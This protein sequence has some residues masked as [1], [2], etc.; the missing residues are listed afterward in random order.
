MHGARGGP[1][2]PRGITRCHQSSLK[3]GFY[4]HE[5]VV[6]RQVRSKILKDKKFF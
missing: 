6:A 3:H 5:A 2:T 4:T 1:K